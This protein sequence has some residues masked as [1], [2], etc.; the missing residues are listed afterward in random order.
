MGVEWSSNS[1]S[2]VE[3]SSNLEVGWNL[4]LWKCEMGHALTGSPIPRS[5]ARCSGTSIHVHGTAVSLGRGSV[6]LMAGPEIL[7]A[8]MVC[9]TMIL[10]TPPPSLDRRWDL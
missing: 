8:I 1:K 6:I 2:R 9:S 5:F 3:Q 4:E 7:F 10:F